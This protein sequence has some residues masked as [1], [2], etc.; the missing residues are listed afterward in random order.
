MSST[1]DI[2]ADGPFGGRALPA[3]DRLIALRRMANDPASALEIGKAAEHLVCADLILSGYRAFL[4]DQGLP[5]DLVVDLNGKLIRIQVKATCFAKNINAD[6]RAERIGYNF[7]VRRRGKNNSGERL[8]ESHCDIVAMAAL[9]IRKIAYL[10]IVEVGQTCQ[11]MVPGFVFAGKFK[12][13]RMHAIDG[14][15]FEDALYR[16]SAGKP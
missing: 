16:F 13:N 8:N 14:L 15:P 4:S 5:Y 3:E 11:L 7:Y 2:I 9:D 12:R 6:G 10:P 1:G